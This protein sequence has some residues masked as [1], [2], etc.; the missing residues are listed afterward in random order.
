MPTFGL[1]AK[2]WAQAFTIDEYNAIEAGEVSD[3]TAPEV[4][5]NTPYKTSLIVNNS[6]KAYFKIY[7][8]SGIEYTIFFEAGYTLRD[9]LMRSVSLFYW[10]PSDIGGG[11]TYYDSA[12]E[13]VA[14]YSLPYDYKLNEFDDPH[15]LGGRRY[16]FTPDETG[17]HIFG[18][19]QIH[20]K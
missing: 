16:K 18:S 15:W 10:K 2:E 7:L 17:Y 6:S 13:D 3:T 8:I 5:L 12:D 20:P 4:D 11:A 9:F 14:P 19:F 1:Y